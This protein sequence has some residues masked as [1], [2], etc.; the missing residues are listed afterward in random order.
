MLMPVVRLLLHRAKKLFFNGC[1]TSCCE[2]IFRVRM[3]L[4][5]AWLLVTVVAPLLYADNPLVRHIYTADP[6]PLIYND[7]FFIFT[8]HDEGG[9]GW[10]LNGWHVLSSTNMVDWTDHG[11]VLG[12]ADVTWLATKQAW[13]AQCV[14]R[15][16]KFYFYIC[17]SGE[18]GVAVADRVLG[19]YRDA[20]GKPLISNKT[21]GACPGDDNIDPTVFID[22]DGTAYIYWGTDRVV[23][24]AKLK[25]SMIEIDG[26]ITVPKGLNRFFEASWVHK[27]DSIYYYSYAAYNASGDNWPSNIDYATSSNPLGPW[28]Y[29]GTLN[30]YAGTGTNHSGIIQFR[31]RWYFVYHTDYLSGGTPWERSV[32]INYLYYNDDGTM[33][34]VVQDTVGVE[35]VGVR[36][37]PQEAVYKLRAVHSGKLIGVKDG[38]ADDKANVEQQSDNGG[39][40]QLWSVAEVER[41]IYKIINKKSGRVLDADEK[42][43]NVM[44]YGWWG[45][46][47]QRWKIT[48]TGSGGYYIVCKANNRMLEVYYAKKDDG[49]NVQHWQFNG[50]TCQMWEFVRVDSN[51]VTVNRSFGD[52]MMPDASS[53]TGKTVIAVRERHGGVQNGCIDL[54]GRNAAGTVVGRSSHGWYFVR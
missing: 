17:D 37:F 38:S 26:E 2:R 30:G 25:N 1:E 29:R 45:G 36:P 50:E 11:E 31:D 19:P 44:Q 28:E 21:A 41:G 33:K 43:D 22:D 40:Q 39:D 27:R 14:E 52:G 4:F 16:G 42:S 20:L 12:V 46:M 6:A 8:G 48:G 23:R 10:T 35:A 3:S 9:S 49:T 18:I 34:K 24:Q 53:R 54:K 15:D 47:N 13:A 32:Q 7:T 51:V 5:C